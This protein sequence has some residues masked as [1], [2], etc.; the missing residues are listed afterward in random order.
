MLRKL[1]HTIMFMWMLEIIHSIFFKFFCWLLDYDFILFV[2][3]YPKFSNLVVAHSETSFFWIKRCLLYSGKHQ[4]RA[5]HNR[6]AQG[7]KGGLSPSEG[8][9]MLVLWE[10]VTQEATHYV[11]H[12]VG[13]PSIVIMQCTIIVPL[14]DISSS[15]FL[16]K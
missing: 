16:R 12:L 10:C 1:L 11:K 4:G 8:P 13:C 9:R 14:C 3:W 6:R 5:I 2:P 7:A 15:I